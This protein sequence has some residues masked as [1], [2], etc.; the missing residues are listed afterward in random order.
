[1]GMKNT[2]SCFLSFDSPIY[3]VNWKRNNAITFWL[4]S[5]PVISLYGQN[6]NVFFILYLLSKTGASPSQF[7]LEK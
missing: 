1:M 5:G 3:F 6:V 2:W 7:F 4:F